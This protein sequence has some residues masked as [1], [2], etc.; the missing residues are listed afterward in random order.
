MFLETWIVVW[1]IGSSNT[2]VKQKKGFCEVSCVPSLEE[3]M[4]MSKRSLY[5]L[6]Y[7]HVQ[8]L[9]RG[10]HILVKLVEI[11]AKQDIARRYHEGMP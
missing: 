7:V 1:M 8:I 6:Y 3:L 11:A 4:V 5:H 9:F 2:G 10:R